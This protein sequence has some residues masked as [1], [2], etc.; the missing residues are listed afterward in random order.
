MRNNPEDEVQSSEVDEPEELQ[1]AF[2]LEAES[3]F[4][5]VLQDFLKN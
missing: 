2:N 5:I 1:M 3:Q 4:N